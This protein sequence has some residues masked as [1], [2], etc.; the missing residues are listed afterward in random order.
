MGS[1]EFFLFPCWFDPDFG[2][3]VT[4]G[5]AVFHEQDFS[6]GTK[7][8]DIRLRMSPQSV[9]D[10]LI[11]WKDVE[12]DVHHDIDSRGMTSV[13]PTF[14]DGDYKGCLAMSTAFLGTLDPKDSRT[15]T[16]PPRITVGMSDEIRVQDGPVLGRQHPGFREPLLRLPREDRWNQ[17]RDLG[18]GHVAGRDSASEDGPAGLVRLEQVRPGREQAFD[19]QKGD[20]AGTEGACSSSRCSA[21]HARDARRT[22]VPESYGV[23]SARLKQTDLV[24]EWEAG[25]R[26]DPPRGRQRPGAHA[27][28]MACRRRVPRCPSVRPAR[29]RVLA[30]SDRSFGRKRTSARG[31]RRRARRKDGHG[32]S[33][34]TSRA[35]SSRRRVSVDPSAGLQ[36]REDGPRQDSDRRARADRWSAR[37]RHQDEDRQSSL[38]SS[39]L[40]GGIREPPCQRQRAERNVQA[41]GERGEEGG[42]GGGVREGS[43]GLVEPFV[44]L[45]SK[46]L[47]APILARPDAILRRRDGSKHSEVYVEE[48]SSYVRYPWCGTEHGLRRERRCGTARL[49]RRLV[50]AQRNPT[51]N[52]R[53]RGDGASFPP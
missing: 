15:P 18:H 41:T 45:R 10:K 4:T 49:H 6:T 35:R 24:G 44:D 23:F 14:P 52:C 48:Q 36:Y 50:T 5:R 43:G 25:L 42:R 51:V 16:L 13:G 26:A 7:G 8:I 17:Y 19:D 27:A 31:E 46:Q 39:R 38:R 53:R 37:V 29:S 47:R 20:N 34:P 1:T 40:S 22:K 32:V 2:P 12:V 33:R 21:R 9:K 28:G 30:R 3:D 11:A